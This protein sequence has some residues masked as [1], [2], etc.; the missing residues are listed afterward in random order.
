M[1]CGLLSLFGDIGKQGHLTYFLGQA[2]DGGWPNYF[3][4]LLAVKLP[5]PTLILIGLG[6]ACLVDR[7]PRDWWDSLFL[8]L[9][10]LLLIGVASSGK[11]QIGIRHILPAFPFFIFGGWLCCSAYT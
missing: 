4:M 11:L 9:P 2:G 5:I 8:I 6:L 1:F 10:P 7:L 3:L